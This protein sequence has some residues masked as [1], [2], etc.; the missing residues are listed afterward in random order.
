MKILLIIWQFPQF[1]IGFVLSKF[2]KPWKT[3]RINDIDITFCETKFKFCFSLSEFVFAPKDASGLVLIHE[4]GHSVQSKWLGWYYFLIVGLP[5]ICLYCYKK[6]AKK[7]EL[8]YHLHYP[9]NWAD[10]ISG[11]RYK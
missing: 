9:E 6:L 2:F 7:D 4:A 1:I 11:I 3:A 8:W 10:K 5:S